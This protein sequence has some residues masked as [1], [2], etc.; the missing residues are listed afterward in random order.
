[1]A[2]KTK[3][4]LVNVDGVNLYA[5]NLLPM[6]KEKAVQEMVVGGIAVGDDETKKKEWAGKAFDFMVAEKAKADKKET[7]GNNKATATP[8]ATPPG[9]TVGQTPEK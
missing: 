1:M 4:F 7:E 9:V 6:G 5:H 3:P 8:A 2:D